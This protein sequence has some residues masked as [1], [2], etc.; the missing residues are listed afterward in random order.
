MAIDVVAMMDEQEAK[1]AERENQ[2]K[3]S[4][5]PTFL[6]LSDKQKCMFRPLNNL[7]GAAVMEMHN[8]FNKAD[9]KLSIDAV[10]AAENG[11]PC[12]HCI[13]AAAGDKK[14]KADRLFLL[15]VYVYKIWY[16]KRGVTNKG[17]AFQAGEVLMET[18]E[19]DNEKP[20]SGI[21]LLKLSFERGTLVP[22]AQS[23]K[24]RY[25][26]GDDLRRRD[27]TLERFGADQTTYYV[28]DAKDPSTFEKKLAPV[29]VDRIRERAFEACPPLAATGD[30]AIDGFVQ[31]VKNAQVEEVSN[32]DIPVF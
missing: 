21:R 14:L 30:P 3:R 12:Q 24:G 4:Y 17:V 7:D 16:T 10:C 9:P 1:A 13:D 18:D 6:R 31:A 29:T 2:P 8:K 20:V 32:D 25:K 22:V 23:L 28:L 26:E 15:P 19:N 11:D 27:F 5:K